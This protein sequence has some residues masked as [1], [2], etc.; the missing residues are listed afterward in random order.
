MIIRL[1][2][3]VQR[4]VAEKR[5]LL[6]HA[7]A[8]GDIPTVTWLLDQP[9]VGVDSGDYDHR[10]ALHLAACEGRLAVV[11]AANLCSFERLI[12]IVVV[13]THNDTVT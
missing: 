1:D 2:M 5:A 13:A 3:A 8:S 7:A 12:V 6:C 10:R 11:R 4:I 9:E